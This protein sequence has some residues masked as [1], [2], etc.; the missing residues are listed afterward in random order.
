[1]KPKLPTMAAR[2]GISYSLVDCLN[3]GW[4]ISQFGC[5]VICQ[6]SNICVAI[7]RDTETRNKTTMKRREETKREKELI[8]DLSKHSAMIAMVLCES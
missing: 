1:M 6:I 5:S 8:R 2:M 7:L 4:I 3:S